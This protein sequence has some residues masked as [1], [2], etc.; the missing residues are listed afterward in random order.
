[1]KKLL[2]T[3]L[4][5][6]FFFSA[7]KKEE[8]CNCGDFIGY[9]YEVET[10]ARKARKGIVEEESETKL[11]L[12]ITQEGAEIYKK[13]LAEADVSTIKCDFKEQRMMY[14]DAE[15]LLW[16]CNHIAATKQ[17][18]M[19]HMNKLEKEYGVGWNSLEKLRIMHNIEKYT[20]F[21]FRHI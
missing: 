11:D 21:L 19:T 17:E 3:F 14:I 1:M 9:D 5:F 10:D 15:M 2:Y 20:S 12:N 6:S 13:V 18:D 8:N 4:A 16:P 7:C